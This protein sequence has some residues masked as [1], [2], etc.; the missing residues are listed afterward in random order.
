[1]QFLGNLEL[2]QKNEEQEGAELKHQRFSRRLQRGRNMLDQVHGGGGGKITPNIVKK[3]TA[4][5]PQ[6]VR[7]NGSDGQSV[8][9]GRREQQLDV[10]A[11][12]ENL[13]KSDILSITY[14]HDRKH[15]ENETELTFPTPI[16]SFSLP[17]P[18]ENERD[19]SVPIQINLEEEPTVDPLVRKDDHGEDDSCKEDLNSSVELNFGDELVSD[20]ETGQTSSLQKGSHVQDD[21]SH[22]QDVITDDVIIQEEGEG[23]MS[24]EHPAQVEPKLLNVTHDLTLDS[25]CDSIE[26]AEQQ[27]DVAPPSQQQ[28]S[29]SSGRAP[30]AYVPPA[31]LNEESI[32]EELLNMSSIL[33]NQKSNL[34]IGNEKLVFSP[35]KAPIQPTTNSNIRVEKSPTKV[36]VSS[37]K[38]QRGKIAPNLARAQTPR[39]ESNKEKE[40]P[41]KS[42]SEVQVREETPT[43]TP[44]LKPTVSRRFKHAKLS[45]FNQ[46]KQNKQPE[47]VVSNAGTSNS[48]L[49]VP[50]NLEV[51]KSISPTPPRSDITPTKEK[52]LDVSL[53]NT[54]N[55][56][57]NND[58]TT[59]DETKEAD[60]A[61]TKM[62]EN[63][64]DF[65]I[66]ASDYTPSKVPD[67]G[68]GESTTRTREPSESS[69][70]VLITFD[71]QDDL[72]Q[73][74]QEQL[75]QSAHGDQLEL[76]PVNEEE[77]EEDDSN[78]KQQQQ[79]Q[80]PDDGLLNISTHPRQ[81]SETESL[82]FPSPIFPKN[83]AEPSTS[84][85]A[86]APS[87]LREMLFLI[88]RDGF[89]VHDS[90]SDEAVSEQNV[91]SSSASCK[92]PGF[93]DHT[94]AADHTKPMAPSSSL[95]KRIEM[96]EVS[97]EHLL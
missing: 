94:A 60:E 89:D 25:L 27:K 46:K 14:H 55:N 71:S 58:N 76:P 6:P 47:A 10:V 34:K 11:E 38:L 3:R 69:E 57:S 8:S 28:Q 80:Q 52:D 51:V 73:E 64:I 26:I 29:H 59:P 35:E 74:Q 77:E 21:T 53:H 7:N 31:K 92:L 65:K 61:D 66:E 48:H 16:D 62:K 1:M 56:S 87:P 70:P 43:A 97:D 40:S 91:P 5:V 22:N 82:D 9:D 32:Q 68:V 84:T 67:G 24:H 90:H 23:E 78:H 45:R 19:T 54:S 83:I 63:F 17:T 12:T 95:S 41:S 37:K 13:S 4:V 96:D 72:E 39:G 88:P 36:P 81:L 86:P 79:P 2:S 75:E 15:L 18:P 50:E 85:Q 44:T 30:E 33:S 49:S 20:D 42:V 93:L